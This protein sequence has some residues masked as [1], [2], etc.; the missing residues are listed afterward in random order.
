MAV[1]AGKK[2]LLIG[3]SQSGINL[4]CELSEEDMELMESP[5]VNDSDMIGKSFAECLKFNAGKLG[6][7][8][9]TPKSGD[10]DHKDG[11]S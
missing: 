10:N 7:E 11:N 4:L 3:V 2:N 9:I 1:R 8:F 6:K 5:S